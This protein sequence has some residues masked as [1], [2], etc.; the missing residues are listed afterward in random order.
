ML[1]AALAALAAAGGTAVVEAAGTDAWAGLRARVAQL[2]GRGDDGRERAELARLDA[3]AAAL[4]G[5]G[6]G[7][8]GGAGS[9]VGQSVRIRQEAFW[10]AR[11]AALLEGPEWDRTAPNSGRCCGGRPRARFRATPS[12]VPQPYRRATTTVRTTGSGPSDD[13]AGRPAPGRRPRPRL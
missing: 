6:P 4:T 10:Q 11:F 3:T 8:G 1:E 13:L 7:D 5:A 9:G 12:P 2:F